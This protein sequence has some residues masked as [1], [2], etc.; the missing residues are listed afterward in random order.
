[1]P[2]A[3]VDPLVEARLWQQFA[4]NKATAMKFEKLTVYRSAEM[5]SMNPQWNVTTTSEKLTRVVFAMQL[6]SAKNSQTANSAIYKHLN[7]TDYRL[8]MGSVV[9]PRDNIVADWGNKQVSRLWRDLLKTF[10]RDNDYDGG[11]AFNYADF[12][13]LYPFV[14]FDFRDSTNLNPTAAGSTVAIE[15]E[16][17]L[18]ADPGANYHIYAFVFSERQCLVSTT[19]RKVLFTMK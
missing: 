1:M 8:R 6:A 3:K 5:S 18:T 12:I 9:L 17:Q 16:A 13:N 4:S 19:E 15:F 14:A 2:Y 7:G 10:D 11:I